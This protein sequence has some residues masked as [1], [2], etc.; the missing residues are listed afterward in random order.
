MTGPKSN[1]ATVRKNGRG[2]GKRREALL[3]KM[4]KMRASVERYRWEGT[5]G[6]GG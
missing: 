4:V 3:V 1:A 6:I 2:R 5:E